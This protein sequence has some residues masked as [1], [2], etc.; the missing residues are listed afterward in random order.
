MS[1]YILA[2]EWDCM[3]LSTSISVLI[4]GSYLLC[5]TV[6]VSDAWD[7]VFAQY[8]YHLYVSLA[9]FF[10]SRVRDAH[11]LYATKVAAVSSP[12]G[13][14]THVMYAVYRQ[15]CCPSG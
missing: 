8:L 15:N 7:I 11:I 6:L 14:L 12:V 4:N 13:C 3:S 9:T 1:R 2:S 10:F 5:I